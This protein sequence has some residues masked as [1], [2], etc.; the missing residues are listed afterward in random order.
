ME[1]P[2]ATTPMAKPLRSWNQVATTWEEVTKK[3]AMPRPQTRPCTTQSRTAEPSPC[4]PPP[5]TTLRR[6]SPRQVKTVP[7]IRRGRW[8]PAS[9]K[10]PMMKD[11]DRTT[12]D[13]VDPMRLKTSS[14][15]FGR[16]TSW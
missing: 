2:V 7:M 9:S 1:A 4:M 13:C 10:R 3:Q 12:K 6:K 5:L 14:L 16:R 8:N 11:R 15:E